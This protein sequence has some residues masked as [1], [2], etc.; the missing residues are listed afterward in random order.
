MVLPITQER[1][2]TNAPQVHDRH[3]R[4]P[5]GHHIQ[6]HQDL[7]VRQVD[8]EEVPQADLIRGHPVVEGQERGN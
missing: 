7:Q 8:P 2:I 4:P 1:A 3:H 6:V 5:V